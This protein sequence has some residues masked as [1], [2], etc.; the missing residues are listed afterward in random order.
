MKKCSVR[1]RKVYFIMKILTDKR[2]NAMLDVI[3]KQ[4]KVMQKQERLIKKLEHDIDL[5]KNINSPVDVIFPN[6]DERGL[7]GDSGSPTIPEIFEM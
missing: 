3:V 4:H 2:Y 6:T 5:L 7:N 1:M